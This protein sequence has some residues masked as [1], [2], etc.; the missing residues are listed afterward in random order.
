MTPARSR[1]NWYVQLDLTVVIILLVLCVIVFLI[2]HQYDVSAREAAAKEKAQLLELARQDERQ[3]ED[4]ALAR[5]EGKAREDAAR[6]DAA[7]RLEEYRKAQ[8]EREAAAEQ[9]QATT[10]KRAADAEAARKK[11]LDDA[12]EEER[13]QKAKVIEATKAA[14]VEAAKDVLTMEARLAILT[15]DTSSPPTPPSPATTAAEQATT[16]S[17][18]ATQLIAYK[19]KAAGAQKTAGMLR[20]QLEALRA[21]RAAFT[22]TSRAT[23]VSKYSREEEAKLREKLEAAE[24]E[25]SESR[26]QM[27]NLISVRRTRRDVSTPELDALLAREQ[28]QWLAELDEVKRKRDGFAEE[29]RQAGEIPPKVELPPPPPPVVETP[30]TPVPE[31]KKPGPTEAPKPPPPPTTYTLK[32]G[33]RI[34]SVRSVDGGDVITVKTENGKLMTLDKKD[35]EKTEEGK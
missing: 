15:G 13:K 34:V 28:Q 1:A 6:A 22:A 31:V 30:P 32:D 3:R 29:L 19:N 16:A 25:L 7:R 21:N 20:E 10:A 12:R 4:A 14:Y 8:K 2:K 26:R 5:K 27:L 35:I 17:A 9:F 23:G 33:K 11:E 24:R 18:R